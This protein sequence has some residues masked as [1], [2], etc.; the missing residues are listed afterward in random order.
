[1]ANMVPKGVNL[2]NPRSS[3]LA[4]L[5]RHMRSFRYRFTGAKKHRIQVVNMSIGDLG[6]DTRRKRRSRRFSLAPEITG[7]LTGWIRLRCALNR[8]TAAGPSWPHYYG[9]IARELAL[10]ERQHKAKK[11]L[12]DSRP[13]DCTRRLDPRRQGLLRRCSTPKVSHMTALA[14]YLSI[15]PGGLEAALPTFQPPSVLS[16]RYIS[17]GVQKGDRSYL[18]IQRSND[19]RGT[20]AVP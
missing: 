6:S 8:S 10:V 18:L 7:V 13:L 9:G 15:Y 19:D 20:F 1:L 11:G 12:Y 17:G 3:C 14:P 4:P 5:D 2:R 16:S